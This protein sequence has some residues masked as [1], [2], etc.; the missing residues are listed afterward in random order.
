MDGYQSTFFTQKNRRFDY[1]V[2]LWRLRTS[3]K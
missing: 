3:Q 2:L 1:T